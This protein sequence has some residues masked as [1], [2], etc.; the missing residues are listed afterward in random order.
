M[1][2]RLDSVQDKMQL[3]FALL[4]L[5]YFISGHS[6]TAN[7]SE[8]FQLSV[9]GNS[10]FCLDISLPV[11]SRG[12]PLKVHGCHVNA[13]S[14]M[15][16]CQ[17]GHLVSLAAPGQC[18][19]GSADAQIGQSL[20]LWD[21]NGYPQQNWEW[22]AHRYSRQTVFL[23]TMEEDAT[24]CMDILGGA[25]LGKGMGEVVIGDCTN[26]VGWHPEYS[27]DDLLLV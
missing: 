8:Y 2:T 11:W 19:D 14:Q 3:M 24:R 10:G 22:D 23:S 12:S 15:W 27:V 7:R 21:C 25:A 9:V 6:Q 20:F 4:Q 1:T 18:L 17:D 16:M 5:P 13:P 26:A